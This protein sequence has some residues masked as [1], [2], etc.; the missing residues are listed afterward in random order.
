MNSGKIKDTILNRTVLKEIKHMDNRFVKP[1]E[2]MDATTFDAKGPFISLCTNTV[3]AENEH[4]VRASIY[5]C[6]NNSYAT[7]YTPNAILV[8]IV[9][10]CEMEEP[11]LRDVMKMI[12]EEA[13]KMKLSIIGGH[14]EVS[15]YVTKPVITITAYSDSAV[16]TER[17]ELE[18]VSEN[19]SI[20][21]TGFAGN[22]GGALIAC[23]NANIIDKIFTDNY[24]RD[25]KKGIE[26]LSIDKEAAVAIR[27]GV[28]TMHDIRTGGVLAALWEL[29]CKIKTGFMVDIKK[30]PIKQETVEICERFDVNPYTLMTMGA[31]LIVTSK[32]DE[33]VGKLEE[34]GIAAA[35]IGNIAKNKDKVILNGEETRFL[36]RPGLDEIYRIRELKEAN[37]L[38]VRKY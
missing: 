17:T 36:D 14:T 30:I 35:V 32:A 1:Y 7:G 11:M 9:I 6:V 15:R 4:D 27:H 5:A 29:S 26:K 2:G 21:M 22:Y 37:K 10:P 23:E 19:D 3:I 18:S 12:T 16:C 38:C 20:V 25:I 31:S 34:N 24:I 8:N 33:L 13:S 28:K